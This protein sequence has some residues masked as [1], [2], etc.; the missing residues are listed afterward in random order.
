MGGKV[1]VMQAGTVLTQQKQVYQSSQGAF[2]E[3][4]SQF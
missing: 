1:H 2:L 3:C 4:R